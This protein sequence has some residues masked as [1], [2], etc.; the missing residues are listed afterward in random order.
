LIAPGGSWLLY[1]AAKNVYYFHYDREFYWT[2]VLERS[3]RLLY[4]EWMEKPRNWFRAL[5]KS[6][7]LKMVQA[8]AMMEGWPGLR[9]SLKVELEKTCRSDG[10]TV[11]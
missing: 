5:L 7:R 3:I 6:T 11:G 8:S 10:Y 9:F 2:A 4:R 1:W